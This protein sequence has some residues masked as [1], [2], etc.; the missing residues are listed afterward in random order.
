MENSAADDRD[1]QLLLERPQIEFTETS[2]A[3]DGRL[4]PQTIKLSNEGW[5]TALATFFATCR[6]GRRVVQPRHQAIQPG[7]AAAK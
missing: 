2:P 4:V 3:A 6:V 5:A 7:E 1:L